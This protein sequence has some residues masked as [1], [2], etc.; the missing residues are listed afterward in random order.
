M[1]LDSIIKQPCKSDVYKIL[2][3]SDLSMALKELL[4]MFSD[5]GSG[6]DQ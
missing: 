2:L 3:F 5:I 4:I 6:T 1:T